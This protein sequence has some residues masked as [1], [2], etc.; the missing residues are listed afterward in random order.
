M[1]NWKRVR[2]STEAQARLRQ[3]MVLERRGSLN[4]TAE[5]LV[6]AAYDAAVQKGL[7]P[8]GEPKQ[9]KAKVEEEV[10]S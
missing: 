7:I 3:I 6:C 9:A 5:A 10:A 4:N 1:A 8:P 2:L